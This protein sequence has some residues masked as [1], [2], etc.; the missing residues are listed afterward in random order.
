M[1]A[2]GDTKRGGEAYYR[3]LFFVG[4]VW[5]WGASIVFFLFYKRIFTLFGMEIPLYPSILHLFVA[6]VLVFGIGYY[7]VS[8]DIQKNNDIVRMGIIGKIL[9]FLLF[10][11][12]SLFGN[13]H[14]LFIAAGAVDLVFAVLFIEFIISSKKR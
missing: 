8:R 11:F 10:L 14:P 6:L 5:N 12:H 2:K 7:W 3:N 13:L 9:V 1:T 4:A